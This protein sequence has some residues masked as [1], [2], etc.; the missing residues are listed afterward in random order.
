M[1]PSPCFLHDT[2]SITHCET[3]IYDKGSGEGKNAKKGEGKQG[4]AFTRIS[5]FDNNLSPNGEEVKAKN[6]KMADARAYARVVSFFAAV[7]RYPI[8]TR[9]RKYETNT[10]ACSRA[11]REFGGDDTQLHR[12]RQ[13]ELKQRIKKRSFVNSIYRKTIHKHP[14]LL[15]KTSYVKKNREKRSGSVVYFHRKAVISQKAN[16]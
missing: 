7:G 14:S 9:N 15:K 11:P 5:L 3:I 13:Q 10:Q 6:R 4:E 8:G 1:K 16:L 12:L 2:S